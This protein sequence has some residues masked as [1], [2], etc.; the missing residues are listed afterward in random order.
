MTVDGGLQSIA[1]PP[2]EKAIEAMAPLVREEEFARQMTAAA[3]TVR[4][5]AGA[6]QRLASETRAI[7]HD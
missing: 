3:E 2:S 5:A 6:L 7:D 4:R 1:K